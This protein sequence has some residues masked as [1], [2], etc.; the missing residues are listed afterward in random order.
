MERGTPSYKLTHTP[1]MLQGV[2]GKWNSPFGFH[3]VMA[4]PT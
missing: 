3:S 1:T 2:R 4:K